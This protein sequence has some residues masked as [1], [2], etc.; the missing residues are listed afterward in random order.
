M[1]F[2]WEFARLCGSF[3]PQDDLFGT[4]DKVKVMMPVCEGCSDIT[5]MT[6]A[7]I[8]PRGGAFQEYR[9]HM[10]VSWVGASGICAN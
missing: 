8:S 4:T 3:K 10:G 7:V 9:K 1:T 2:K 5:Q 6:A